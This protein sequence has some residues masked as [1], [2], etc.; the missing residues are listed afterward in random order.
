MVD[1]VNDAGGVP[2]GRK[3]KL[4]T[5][6]MKSDAALAGT[7]AQEPIGAGAR[8]LRGSPTDD[9]LIPMACSRWRSRSR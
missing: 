8:V 9:G 3:L 7:A 6:D 2:G 1:I 5:R 4:L